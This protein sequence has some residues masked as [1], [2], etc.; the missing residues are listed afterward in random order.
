MTSRVSSR[1]RG[2]YA[3][4]LTPNGRMLADL[5]VYRRPDAWLLGLAAE[6]AATIAERLDQSIFSEDVRVTD[7]TAALAELVVVGGGAAA[8]A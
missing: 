7:V 5:E 4:Y 6:R 8:A 2:C 1:A 3:T